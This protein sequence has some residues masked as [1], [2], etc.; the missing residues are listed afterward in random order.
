MSQYT[1]TDGQYLKIM[2][3]RTSIGKTAG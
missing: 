3:T 2:C 1:I